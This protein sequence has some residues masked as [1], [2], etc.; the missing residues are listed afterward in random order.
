MKT[1]RFVAIICL[2]TIYS[3]KTEAIPQPFE[4]N[5]VF[6]LLE[7]ETE[8]TV[9]V[10]KP[11]ESIAN[12]YEYYKGMVNIPATVPYK[13]EI[14]SVTGIGNDA[15]AGQQN[16]TTIVIPKSVEIIQYQAF[17]G[18]P[19]L[20]SV[21]FVSDGDLK[22]IERRAFRA[23][24]TLTSITL[25]KSL[26]YV[27][28]D[29]FN[30]CSKL[31]SVKGGDNIE[32]FDNNAFQGCRS[33]E[34]F[35]CPKSLKRIGEFAF[36]ECNNLKTV[37]MN[38]GL[39]LI[40][41]DA[42]LQCETLEKVILSN[43]VKEIGYE[44]FRG[45]INLTDIE[46]PNSVE[47]MGYGVFRYCTWLKNVKLGNSLK[48]IPAYAFEQTPLTSIEI[49][50]SVKE[51]EIDAFSGCLYLEDIKWGNGLT[52]IGQTAFASTN[53]NRLF[54]PEPLN[55]IAGGAFAKCY[56]LTEVTIPRTVMRISD[57]AFQW[58]KLLK[59]VYIYAT[60]PPWIPYTNSPFDQCNVPIDVHVYEG[61][62]DIY[63]KSI[64]WEESVRRGLVRF[65]DDIHMEKAKAIIINNA[66]YYCELGCA[67]QAS[68]TIYPVNAVQ[69]VS[70][71]SS[72][73]SILYIEEYTG[74]Y[75]GLSQGV[76]TITATATDGSGVK[77]FANVYVGIQAGF[78]SLINPSYQPSII[79][80]LHGQRMK[81]PFKGLNVINGVKMMVK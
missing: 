50:N 75:V 68:A 10:V 33:L 71:T 8:K 80:N 2:F 56:S 65:I 59:T 55:E 6:Y 37:I 4:Y 64:G 34:E 46:I 47:K 35:V 30:G 19:N 63:E 5:G 54:L 3:L 21:V 72:D 81:Q 76:V 27:G 36:W 14:Y 78:E 62:K 79:Y 9:W 74:Q 61:Y 25:P 23:C 24:K 1:I 40:D 39:E 26:T 51:I 49:P 18:C 20:T 12:W 53:L 7:S 22:T 77:G 73:E 17:S 58:C 15:F 41:N 38:E 48:Y 57:S 16:L 29:V 11:Y 13:G 43:T 42:F 69:E 45:C 52:R 67:G 66:P 32:V 60:T 31:K 44:A 70:W 28:E